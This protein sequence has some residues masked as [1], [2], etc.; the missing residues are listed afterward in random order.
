MTRTNSSDAACPAS[1]APHI[2][3]T[4]GDKHEALRQ[5]SAEAK[6]KYL[7]KVGTIAAFLTAVSYPTVID[8]LGLPQFFE[9]QWGFTSMWA[10]AA[11]AIIYL[12]PVMAIGNILLNHIEK[13]I[14]KDNPPAPPN[15][16]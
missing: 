10:R 11:G 12:T 3:A 14:A 13:R 5:L 6:L 15:E 2:R 16:P 4:E 9:S 7:N 1:A 8:K